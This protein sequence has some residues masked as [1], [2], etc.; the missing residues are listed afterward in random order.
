MGENMMITIPSKGLMFGGLCVAAATVLALIPA[1]SHAGE[2]AEPTISEKLET[3]FTRALHIVDAEKTFG[4]QDRWVVYIGPG[5]STVALNFL[6]D[7][8]G[9]NRRLGYEDNVDLGDAQ[10]GIGYRRGTMQWG[11]GYLHRS[12]NVE[13]VRTDQGYLA[14]TFS[15]KLN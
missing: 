7:G 6:D 8:F 9:W 10:L 14:F 4:N 15:M 12:L 2:F 5:D 3:S 11:F 1:V 13:N